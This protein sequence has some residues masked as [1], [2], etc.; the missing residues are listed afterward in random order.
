MGGE[1]RFPA[2]LFIL[3]GAAGWGGGAAR[4]EAAD[5]WRARVAAP[6]AALYDA[7]VQDQTSV[8]A[9]RPSTPTA[10]GGPRLDALGRV[11]V[12]VHF[13]CTQRAPS[14]QLAAAGFSAGTTVKLA[15]LC[16]AEGWL[17]PAS[18]PHVAAVAG[19]TRLKV[20]SYVVRKHPF[21]HALQHDGLSP[22]QSLRQSQRPDAGSASGI[23]HN[24]V[25][26]MRADQFVAQSGTGGPNVTVGVQSTGV[27]SLSLIQGRDELP[28]VQ[29]VNPAGGSSSAAADE[30]TVLLEEVHAV[31]PNAGLAYC[32][33]DTFVEYTSCL[34]A[35]IGAGASILVDD[36]VF[37]TE[38]LI[39]S[40]SSD[41]QAIEQIL[42]QNPRVA[43]FTA[44][45]N[46][47][48]SYWEGNYS[49][50]AVSSVS[51]LGVAALT[52]PSGGSTQID[53]YVSDMGGTPGQILTVSGSSVYPLVL[54][55]ADP[56]GHNASKFDVYWMGASGSTGN[57]GCLSGTSSMGPQVSQNLSLPVG[58]YTLYV[59]TPDA[60][61]AGKFIKLWVGG[62]GLTSISKPTA[63]SLV[64]PQAFANGAISIGA[65]KGSDGVGNSI[66]SFSSL[67]P[68]TFV[69][70]TA[71]KI[72]APVLVAPD[73]INVDAA[74]TYFAG[75]LFPDG[76]FYGT[77]A[78]V[79][80]AGAVA[81][82]LHGAFPN[83]TVPQLVTALENGATQ[84]GSSSPDN[85]FG[86]GR[87]DAI[88]ALGTLPAP[89]MTSL[90]N[91][92][93]T[94]GMSTAAYPFTVSGTGSLHFSVKSSLPTV[95]P[96][97]VVAAGNAGVT[98]APSTCGTTSLSCTLSVMP[99]SGPGGT[100]NLTVAA[101]DGAGRSA[102]AS[103]TVA[104]AAAQGAAP[105]PPVS[106]GP[107]PA[108]GGGGGGAL[109]W[110]EILSLAIGLYAQASSRSG[111]PP[112]VSG[113]SRR[114]LSRHAG[115]AEL[116]QQ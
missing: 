102:P 79:P 31:A 40:D 9:S 57:N 62:D 37:T 85:T 98:I 17:A 61:P 3:L 1:R 66:E 54:S 78:S 52:C 90:P 12:D 72:Q 21:T 50:V 105:N 68:I 41:V 77:S 111:S 63:G 56:P 97:Q 19:V 112:R 59:A 87:I 73:G 33:P 92:S 108:S 80:N 110:W 82:L 49:P 47:N 8:A 116:K 53:N 24:G 74:G 106:S 25:S 30:G 109:G 15:T 115:A 45:G 22:S 71:S 28:A 89:T 39:S 14:K 10:P 35:L 36:V 81:A 29:V 113:M 23:D 99:A 38:D 60:S 26:I 86:Y 27:A 11:Q 6:L 2:L 114:G 88:G 104:V 48:G 93:V 13:D 70:P 96:S 43:L 32:G 76:N 64:T 94:A 101:V 46:Y 4:T 34:G 83:L 84:L 100:V 67:G 75:Y 95:I 44:A 107:P 103:M 42:T 16:V 58:T 69:F 18:I 55:W 65:V 20:P 5:A 51:A 7:A 91:S